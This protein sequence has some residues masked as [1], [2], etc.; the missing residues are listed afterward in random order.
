[1]MRLRGSSENQAAITYALEWRRFNTACATKVASIPSATWI[2]YCGIY[3]YNFD[4]PAGTL[5]L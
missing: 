5:H 4:V 2:L 3:S 1:M